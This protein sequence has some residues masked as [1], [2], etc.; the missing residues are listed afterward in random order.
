MSARGR[1]AKVLNFADAR[2][3]AERRLPRSVFDYVDGGADDEVTLR[4]NTEKFRDISFAPRSG[5]WVAQPDLSTTVLG[6]P[7][8]FPVLTAPCGGMR[9][10]HPRGDLGIAAAASAAGT[11]HVATSASGFTLEEIAETP[12]NQW[13]QAYR[14]SDVAAMHALVK[15]AEVAGYSALV[16][17]IDTSVSGNREKDF[18]NGFSFN[19]Q[20]D[21]ANIVRMAPKMINRPGW[22]ARF[23]GDGMPFGLPNTADLTA[24]GKGMDLTEMLKVGADSHSPTWEDIAWMRAN[25]S[26]PLVVKGILTVEDAK[27]AASLGADGIVVSNHGGRQLDGAPATIAVLPA[28]VDAVGGRVEVILDSGIRRG[29]DVVKAL[30]LGAKAVLA[31]RYPAYGL[32]TAGDAGVTHVLELLRSEMTRTMRLVGSQRVGDLDPSW[33]SNPEGASAL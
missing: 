20:I 22:V 10:V 9:L 16:A 18:R 12:G 8:S 13:F 32:A 17:T 14:F 28:I 15:R 2:A 27:K 7:V 23:V 6:Q 4:A 30:S 3:F 25:W 5:V 11:I 29:S 33:V 31:G 1:L 19:M 21:L 24:D 26:G